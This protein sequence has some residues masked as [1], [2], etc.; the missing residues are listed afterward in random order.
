MLMVM[1]QD[2]TAAALPQVIRV[3]WAL[4]ALINQLRLGSCLKKVQMARTG[5]G[6]GEFQ[7]LSIR[8][9]HEWAWKGTCQ[10]CFCSYLPLSEAGEGLD[11]IMKSDRRSWDSHT[12][13]PGAWS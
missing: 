4:R 9:V 2:S 11:L 5:L 6:G 3:D 7:S 1:E 10:G 12:S 13:D 8:G